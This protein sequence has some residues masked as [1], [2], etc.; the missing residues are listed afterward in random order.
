MIPMQKTF[1]RSKGAVMD[2]RVRRLL[3][4][5]MVESLARMETGAKAFLLKALGDKDERIRYNAASALY[6]IGARAKKDGKKNPFDEETWTRINHE[7]TG[8]GHEGIGLLGGL[9][10]TRL[11]QD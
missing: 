6:T 11:D 1:A 10:E 7:L 2:R 4:T 8:V 9:P 5:G 3:K